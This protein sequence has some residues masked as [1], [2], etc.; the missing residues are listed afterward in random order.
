MSGGPSGAGEGVWPTVAP[1][2]NADL[3]V[4]G[5]HTLSDT[6]S[7]FAVAL[8]AELPQFLLRVLQPVP[9]LQFDLVADLAE[10]LQHGVVGNVLLASRVLEDPREGRPDAG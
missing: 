3:A 4:G 9:Y 5:F 8:L 6:L 1:A 7:A 2:G 10:P